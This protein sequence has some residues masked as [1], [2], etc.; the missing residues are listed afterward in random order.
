[1]EVY[2][3]KKIKQKKQKNYNGYRKGRVNKLY[4]SSEDLEILQ[5]I[6][7]YLYNINKDNITQLNNNFIVKAENVKDMYAMELY[8][9]LYAINE[10][11]L[12]KEITK[13]SE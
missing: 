2:K 6:E 7:L 8:L 5:E 10:K 13:R 12:K 1:M 4:I 11:L 9:K 3:N